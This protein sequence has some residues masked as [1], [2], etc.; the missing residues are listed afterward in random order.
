VKYPY[1]EL[2]LVYTTLPF[3]QALRK[4]KELGKKLL[5]RGQQMPYNIEGIWK[6]KDRMENAATQL[7]EAVDR[8]RMKLQMS[9]AQFSRRVLGISPSY[10]CRLKSGERALTL[11]MLRVFIQKFPELAPAVTEYIMR[12]GDGD[13]PSPMTQNPVASDTS[14]EKTAKTVAGNKAGRGNTSPTTLPKR[15]T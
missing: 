2:I 6:D 10:L 8:E 15:K 9:D 3:W 4:F 11:D 13:N 5:T 7:L 12:Q 1:P 14:P